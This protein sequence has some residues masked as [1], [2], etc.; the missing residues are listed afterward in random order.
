MNNKVVEKKNKLRKDQYILRKK[1]Y[2]SVTKVFD[3][4]LIENLFKKI[5]LKKVKIISSFISTNSE[6]DTK[7][8]NNFILEK[9]KILCLPVVSKKY[10]YLLFREFTSNKDMIEG[11]MKIKEPAITNKILIPDVLFI[12]CLAFD[13]FGFR[14]GYGGGYYDK[15]LNHLK[16]IDKKFLSIGYA[17][18]GQKVSDV[19]K[20]KLDMKLDYV[21]TEKKLYSFV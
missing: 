6:I 7:E 13:K 5:N 14:L 8:L 21:I 17:F 12:P 19:P 15:T 20:D 3:Q 11:F 2:S 1:L 9:N 4:S 10:N 18:E 16:K